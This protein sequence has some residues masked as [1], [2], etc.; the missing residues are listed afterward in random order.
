MK[1]VI[2]FLRLGGL[3]SSIPPIPAGYICPLQVQR[4]HVGLPRSAG[5]HTPRLSYLSAP[6]QL[7]RFSIPSKLPTSAYT[8][9]VHAAESLANVNTAARALTAHAKTVSEWA[10]ERGLQIPAPKSHITLFTSEAQQFNTDHLSS[11]TTPHCRWN[12]TPSYWA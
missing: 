11:S 7:I 1:V 4:C 5:R 6:F 2:K 8:D 12:V 3:R 10:Q 9:D